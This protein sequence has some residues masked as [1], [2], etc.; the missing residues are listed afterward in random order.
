MFTGAAVGQESVVNA[1]LDAITRTMAA[2]GWAQAERD[3]RG[4][5][6]G[7]TRTDWPIFLVRNVDY[8]IRGFC[9]RDCSDLDL[10]LLDENNNEVAR[11]TRVD[12]TPVVR[13]RPGATG[14]FRLQ[15]VMEDCK[16]APCNYGVRM[17]TP[18]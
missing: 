5:L 15:V 12:D 4:S 8:D 9:D 7:N 1:Q 3:I 16:V 14:Q 10:V 17:F 6:R 11:D 13:A 2:Q 18:R